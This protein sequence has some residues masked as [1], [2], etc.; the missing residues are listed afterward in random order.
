L[1]RRINLFN[2]GALAAAYFVHIKSV[3][4]DTKKADD[5]EVKALIFESDKEYKQAEYEEIKEMY[6]Y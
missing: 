3:R 5:L 4:E 6:Q 2:L 1:P